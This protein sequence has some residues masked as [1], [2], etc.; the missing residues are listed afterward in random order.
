MENRKLIING[1]GKDMLRQA[2][3]I[4]YGQINLKPIH[5]PGFGVGPVNAHAWR[6][7]PNNGLALCWAAKSDLDTEFHKP[8]DPYDA[9]T[10]VFEWLAS[11]EA[12]LTDKSAWHASVD[13][14]YLRSS[15][16]VVYA[17][18]YHRAKEFPHAIC[19]IKPT[20]LWFDSASIMP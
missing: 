11:D 3:L 13:R 10:F 16:W 7:D 1:E 9:A 4:A 18:P 6:F 5:E 17:E 12:M 2:L 20:D 8:M 19:L 15:G 14:E